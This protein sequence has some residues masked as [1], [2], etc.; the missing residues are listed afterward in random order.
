MDPF[1]KIGTDL[2]VHGYLFKN[3]DRF[4][5]SWIPFE[6]FGPILW[7]VDPFL[8][9]W[10]DFVVRGSLFKNSDRFGGS[11]SGPRT[12]PAVRATM[13]NVANCTGGDEND[14]SS[15]F[16]VDMTHFAFIFPLL[17]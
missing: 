1:L 3:W 9:I 17:S 8:K 7:F 15:H 12:G 4:C 2:A 13:L 16:G 11:K 6:K 5:G 10:T 14:S